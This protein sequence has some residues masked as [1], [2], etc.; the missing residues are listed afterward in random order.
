M[1]NLSFN[2]VTKPWIEVSDLNGRQKTLSLRDVLR[3]AHTIRDIE[4]GQTPLPKVAIFRL[5]LAILYKANLPGSETEAASLLT[6]GRFNEAGI[7]QYL[8]RHNE[9]FFLDS[10]TR[11]FSQWGEF[12]LPEKLKPKPLNKLF[13]HYAAGGNGTR[14]S[15]I[16]ERSELIL[17][18]AEAARAVVTA[19]LFAVGGGN[20][21]RAGRN[22][23]DAL[24]T[25]HPIWTMRGP[26]LFHSLWLHLF[27]GNRIGNL[28]PFVQED[29][30][31]SPETDTPL[32]ERPADKEGVDAQG[33]RMP[34]GPADSLT[35]PGRLIRLVFDEET[36][37][38][39]MI[40]SQGTALPTAK[41]A[42]YDPCIALRYFEDDDEIKPTKPY[43]PLGVWRFFDDGILFPPG[44]NSELPVLV[45]WRKLVAQGVM[46]ADDYFLEVTAVQTPIGADA[47][48]INIIHQS[49]PGAILEAG[50]EEVRTA[51]VWANNA[52]FAVRVVARQVMQKRLSKKASEV[53]LER[54][55]SAIRDVATLFIQGGM[56]ATLK[57][58]DDTF[59]QSL[60]G[61]TPINVLPEVL[62]IYGR[63]RYGQDQKTTK[64]VS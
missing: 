47:S 4:G 45:R 38:R 14:H 62:D 11:P 41:A 58:M 52:T 12:Q 13:L 22:F 27:P 35:L 8:F 49:V 2:L 24:G 60:R 21:G 32:W 44:R 36:V 51:L 55:V 7:R 23:R 31:Y 28:F 48:L 9:S 34:A 26:S 37:A 1:V 57:S 20:S 3:D 46:A 17:N 6:K 25:K 56:P 40:F 42:L 33:F 61:E 18:Q 64:E 19:T 10:P 63:V 54:K 5:L 39:E 59:T 30:P 16:H 50:A 43:L 53:W 29:I 15:H